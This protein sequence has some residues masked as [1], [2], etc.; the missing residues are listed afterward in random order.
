[1]QTDITN[2][3]LYFR[4]PVKW[5]EMEIING[6]TRYCSQCA[7]QVYD[8]TDAKQAEF[9]RI[10]AENSN[11]ICGRFRPE[12]MAPQQPA[13]IGLW[14]KWA[15]AALVLIGIN[16]LQGKASAQAN[17]NNQPVQHDP[18]QEVR[19]DEPVGG[20][21]TPGYDVSPSFPGG[22][23]KFKDFM[24]THLRYR[25]GMDEGNTFVQ[26]IFFEYN[27]SASNSYKR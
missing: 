8:L 4:C 7:K 14:K 17:K 2:V 24:A 3:Q 15:S 6:A 13:K 9:M 22:Q 16:L 11:S 26:F 21:G 5:D 10:L 23:Q 1:M 25:E 20:S 27:G 12:Q 18:S 19:I